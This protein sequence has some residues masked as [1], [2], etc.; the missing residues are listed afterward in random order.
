MKSAS[1]NRWRNS[2]NLKIAKISVRAHFSSA[3]R[4]LDHSKT[5]RDAYLMDA[6]QIQKN[7]KNARELAF[8]LFPNEQWIGINQHI[9]RR[10]P[11]PPVAA[12]SQKY[13]LRNYHRPIF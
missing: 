12:D 2:N 4:L 11:V 5:I 1:E 7:T 6:S 8:R 9:F 10:L 13:L 3:H